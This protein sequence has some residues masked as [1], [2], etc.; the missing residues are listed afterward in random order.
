MRK[1][2]TDLHILLVE[3][4]SGHIELI[5]RALEGI[6]GKFIVA[7]ASTIKEAQQLAAK[8]T[9]DLALV[10][11]RLPD[12]QGDLIIALGKDSFPV[13]ILT[14]H[15]D[16][17]LAVQAIKAGALDYVAKSPE[18]FETLPHIVERALREWQLIQD[19][20]EAQLVVAKLRQ[21][22]ET[23][24]EAIFLTD[25][26]GIF[27]YINPG[28]TT[29]YG[30]TSDELIGKETP[31]VLKSNLLTEEVYQQFWEKI[32]SGKEVKG[33]ILNKRKD[34]SM[35]I[36]DGSASPILDMDKNII[37]YLGMQRD[38]SERKQAEKKL[39]KSEA[40]YRELIDTM[41]DGVYKS[42]HEGK[43][44][45]VNPALVKIL[46]YDSREELLAIDIKTELYFKEEDR[47]SVT[48]EEQHN[49]MASYRLRKKDGSEVWVEDHGRYVLDDDGN[50]LF[51]EGIIRDITERK[52][53]EDVLRHAQKMESIG[54]LAGGI[55]HDFNNLLV[56][57]LGQAS[58]ALKKLPKENPAVSNIMKSI[59]AS[60]RAAD[61]VRQLL[62]YSGKGKF[63]TVEI[64]LNT[65]VKENIQMLEVSIPKTAHL[66]YE[67][68]SP[69]PHIIGDIGQFQ[70]V[71]M[72]LIINA[73]ESM[74]PNPGYI[75]IRTNRIELTENNAEY[76][77]YTNTPLTAGSYALLQVKDTG[78]GISQGILTRIFDPFF[79]T[80][81][82]GRGLGLAA[83][84]GIIKGHKGGLRIESEEGKGT[85]FEIVLP[86][87]TTSTL[88]GVQ[89]EKK[90]SAIEGEG[91]T[92]LIIDDDPFVFQLLEDILTEV[93]FKVIGASDPLKG[94]ELYRK[95]HQ[96]ISM[97]ILDFSMPTMNGKDTFERLL[98][99]NKN[100]K[101]LLCSGYSEE[102][103][104]SSFG[105]ERPTGFF[106]KPYN[107][108]ALVKWV[109]EMLSDRRTIH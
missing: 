99:I 104:L 6:P 67:L 80:K 56:G 4:E 30:Y 98:Q 34:G 25:R 94:I 31:R 50:I 106:Q 57:I 73:G 91:K 38:V 75:I 20:K 64:D 26:E 72:N 28:F 1:K 86:L 69:S 70:Q 79:T 101:V 48:L 18:S 42:S 7:V 77:K 45:E 63:F 89:E 3:D 10:D 9:P 61:L 5:R 35:V 66:Q 27:T 51:H 55:A 39:E 90:E 11:Y 100:V 74:G 8:Q 49:E 52:K 17:Q 84:L 68:G 71:I 53:A 92:I 85:L 97:I 65:L 41:P 46:G 2:E 22:I 60:E 109:V 83:V 88:A 54:T 62:A 43:F 58:L 44:I 40:R 13:I 82:T 33:E 14:S 105:K 76:S 96:N 107:T 12:G 24:G 21:A 81:F 16:E 47:D 102:E 93:H 108:E 19:G 103:T 32:S 95:G 87:V 59:S 15:G 37:G 29:L 78:S 36:I 23:S